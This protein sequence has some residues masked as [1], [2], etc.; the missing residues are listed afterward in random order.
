MQGIDAN[1]AALVNDTV[2]VLCA[3]RYSFGPDANI[4]VVMG[5]GKL[6]QSICSLRDRRTWRD[7][8]LPARVLLHNSRMCSHIAI[9]LGCASFQYRKTLHKRDT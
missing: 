3:T 4:A 8:I 7:T 1:V 2:G 9:M 6:L 5:T